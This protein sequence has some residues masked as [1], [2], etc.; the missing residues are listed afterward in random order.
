MRSC[1][2]TLPNSKGLAVIQWKEE[3]IN[4]QEEE[5]EP[6]TLRQPGGPATHCYLCCEEWRDHLTNEEEEEEEV[7]KYCNLGLF[8][9]IFLHQKPTKLRPILIRLCRKKKEKVSIL[10]SLF[11]PPI[12]TNL[13][14]SSLYFIEVSAPWNKLLRH[15]QHLTRSRSQSRSLADVVSHNTL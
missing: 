12:T 3:W 10:W 14:A 6:E 13:L 8:R 5:Y 1:S 4:Q 9:R 2:H 7:T 11:L 15:C